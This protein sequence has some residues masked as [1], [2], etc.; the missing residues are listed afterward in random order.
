MKTKIINVLAIT[1]VFIM[2]SCNSEKKKETQISE[3]PQL[4]AVEMEATG[5]NSRTSLDWDG[6]YEGEVPCADCEGI[7]TIVIINSD[8]TYTIQETYLGKETTPI[9]TKGT[10][11]WDD[12]GQRILLSNDR[13]P[14]FVG[15]NTL[16]L[17]D[18]EGNKNN[19]DLQEF[20]VLKKVMD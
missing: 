17:L 10:F 20:Y 5:D 18:S 8:K 9:E 19:G 6:T 4:E 13:N 14:Y 16:T 7:K 3:E 11:E 1:V 15:E 2:T 12:Q